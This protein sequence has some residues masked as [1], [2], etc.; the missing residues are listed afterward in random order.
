M[1]L[2]SVVVPAY[3]ASEFLAECIESILC[4]TIKDW[5]LILIDDG[6]TDNT[7]EIAEQYSSLNPS[8]IRVARTANIGVSAARN[9]GIDMAA[10]RYIAFCDADDTYLQDALARLAAILEERPECD[11]AVGGFVNARKL[12][13]ISPSTDKWVIC[14]AEQCLQHTLYQKEGYHCSVWAKLYRAELFGD[15]RFSPCRYEDLEITPRL[16]LRARNI[17][18]SKA[19]VYFYRFNPQSF[20]NTWST[21]RADVLTVTDGIALL[22]S[23]ASSALRTAAASRR[24]SAYFNMLG[25]A[26]VNKEPEL[27][28]KCW[29]TI[30]KERCK[31]VADPSVRFKNKVGAIASYGGRRFISFLFEFKSFFINFA[32]NRAT[33]P[34]NTKQS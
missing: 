14:D 33:K 16:Y 21:R 15:V 4:Q 17:A 31:A 13:A 25:E 22:L 18:I 12:K 9:L 32:R 34:N 1:P 7:S 24:F 5:E 19:P 27:E 26:C 29:A 11:I 20:I 23:D 6:S 2:I 28:K 10:G 3:N 8:K 30:K